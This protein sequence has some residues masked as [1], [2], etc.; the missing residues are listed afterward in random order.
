MGRGALAGAW[1]DCLGGDDD[2]DD[3]DTISD[4]CSV[5]CG[6]GSPMTLC[7]VLIHV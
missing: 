2:D 3:D 6:A 7:S 5:V 4:V 1:G